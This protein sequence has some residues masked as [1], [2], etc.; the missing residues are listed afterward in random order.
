M[1][2]AELLA[3]QY[4]TPQMRWRMVFIGFRSDLEI[5][6]GAGFPKPTH[7][8]RKIGELIPNCTIPP[9]DLSGF[10][11]TREAIGDLPAIPAGGSTSVYEGPPDR[12]YQRQMRAGLGSDLYN[13]YAARLSAQNVARLA[14]LRPGEDW[15]DLP[16]D[17]CQPP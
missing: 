1:A 13:H 2:F 15:R 17:C 14:A 6:P 8:N 5:P 9:E 4:G 16:P 12:D 3:A 7:G 11:T 10:V